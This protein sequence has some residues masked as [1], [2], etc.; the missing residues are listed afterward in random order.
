MVPPNLDP[1]KVV[2]E[3]QR[4]V[5]GYYLDAGAWDHFPDMYEEITFKR[6][7]LAGFIPQERGE[8]KRQVDDS[9]WPWCGMAAWEE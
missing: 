8:P 2:Q 5:A 7:Q 4:M 6:L 3:V 9:H 1:K